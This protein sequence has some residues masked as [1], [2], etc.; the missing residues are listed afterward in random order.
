M[1]LKV[2]LNSIERH[3]GFVYQDT[4]W[5]PDIKKKQILIDITSQALQGNLLLLWERINLRH[6]CRKIVSICTALG[7]CRVLRLRHEANR[8]QSL[9]PDC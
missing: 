5:D 8:L 1:Q 6:P 9:W 4:N 2:I 3:K 7:H